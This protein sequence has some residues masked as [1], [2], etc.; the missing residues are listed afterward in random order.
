MFRRG[1]PHTLVLKRCQ[2]GRLLIDN[3]HPFF[4]DYSLHKETYMSRPLS[5]CLFRKVTTSS[6]RSIVGIEDSWH[7]ILWQVTKSTRGFLPAAFVR[8]G[9]STLRYHPVVFR[10]VTL[11]TDGRARVLVG[12]QRA[13]NRLVRER[14][15]PRVPRIWL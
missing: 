1:T 8:A 3:T 2:R 5:G 14:I 9:V 15:P 7:G 11:V 6:I 10:S 4:H 13:S 12:S